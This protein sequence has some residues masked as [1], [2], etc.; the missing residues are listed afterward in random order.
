[1][2]RLQYHVKRAWDAANSTSISLTRS[3]FDRLY[4]AL[5]GVAIGSALAVA[6]ACVIFSP[7]SASYDPAGLGTLEWTKG[8]ARH[9]ERKMA[10][11]ALTL[12]LGGTL[13]GVGAWLRFGGRR[14][15]FLSIFL[16]AMTV[17]VMTEIIGLAMA[18]PAPIAAALGITSAVVISY[19][20]FALRKL[21]NLTPSSSPTFAIFSPASAGQVT[22][23][24]RPALLPGVA[25]VLLIALFV[26]PTSARSIATAIGF[27]MHMASFMVG[28]ATYSFGSHLV[29]GIDYF[30]QYSVGTPWLFS[31]FLAPTA[32]DTMV[33]AVWFVIAEILFFQVTLFLFLWW[34]LRSWA[35]AVVMSIAI[36][37]T[38]FTT[39]APLYAPSSTAARY[40]LLMLAA[41]LFVIWVKRRSIA[42]F[43]HSIGA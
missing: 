27:D 42:D 25:G 32:A 23:Q 7:P 24:F 21:Q 35:W 17:P 9:D 10:F 36:L 18:A 41:I 39:S 38:Q 31:F 4:G 22:E 37:M 34:F 8:W 13:G 2:L 30:T 3:D 12:L 19:V 20:S 5:I 1:M 14:P 33:N 40:P 11:F 29:P 43:D 28:P 26:V 16:L 15:T 6:V